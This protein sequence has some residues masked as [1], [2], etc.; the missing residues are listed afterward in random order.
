MEMQRVTLSDYE[1]IPG[2]SVEGIE[3]WRCPA[4][5]YGEH[6]FPRALEL[7]A[8]IAVELAT[9]PAPLSG[10]AIR[11]LR[12]ASGMS[13]E[14][15]A[16]WSG[17]PPER[18]QEWEQGVLAPPEAIQAALRQRVIAALPQTRRMILAPHG[19]QLAA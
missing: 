5:G 6:S 15:F 9:H 19:W 2:L 8:R 18:V 11:F 3:E 17:H 13:E 7:H 16:V 12:A 4:C 1:G 14:A 10:P